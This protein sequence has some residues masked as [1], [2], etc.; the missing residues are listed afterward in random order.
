M[1]VAENAAQL[2]KTVTMY[3][4]GN[5]ELA[6]Q[7]DGF[8][9]DKF[10]VDRRPIKRLSASS[11]NTSVTVEFE[12]G[13]KKEETFLAHSPQTVTQGPFVEQLG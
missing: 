3:T 13:S 12:D 5:E 7:L 4:H 2:S 1:H 11:D 9:N 8:A 10:K 6:G